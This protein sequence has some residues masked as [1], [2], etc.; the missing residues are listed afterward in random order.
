AT[1]HPEL[2]G[3]D[4]DQIAEFAQDFV[5]IRRTFDEWGLVGSTSQPGKLDYKSTNEMEV[6]AAGDRHALPDTSF[7]SLHPRP[8]TS[9]EKV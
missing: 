7:H 4:D 3:I 6:H 5:E 9:N 1:G 2:I 8:E